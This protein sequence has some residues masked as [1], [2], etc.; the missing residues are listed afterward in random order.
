MNKDKKILYHYCSNQSFLNIV[1]TSKL[2]LFNITKSNDPKEGIYLVPFLEQALEE[3]RRIYNE[4]IA[5]SD[6][7][8][9]EKSI[10][11]TVE[12]YFEKNNP[13]RLYCAVCFS[14]AQDKLSQWVKYADN[15]RGFALG[16]SMEKLAALKQ[17]PY[18]RFGKVIYD[19]TII[20]K[21]VLAIFKPLYARENISDA[22]RRSEFEN[23]VFRAVTV[24]NRYAPFYKDDFFA[25]EE[26]WR[27]VF[28]PSGNINRVH[29][30]GSE[31]FDYDIDGNV[32][33][34]HYSG[35]HFTVKKDGLCSYVELDFSGIKQ[36]FLKEVVVPPNAN[37]NRFDGDLL[38]FLRA[39]GYD[40]IKRKDIE[41][42]KILGGESEFLKIV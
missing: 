30:R 34:F 36:S 40:W 31:Y 42:L 27:L 24:F 5:D 12:R 39:N 19:K 7:F 15:A 29:V 8:I 6:C 10:E 38:L 17:S 13:A 37:L 3:Q 23:A 28:A 20:S 35:M 18:F 21:E 1:S 14:E 16:F 33:G 11:Q 32:A 2:R 9:S 41:K 25:E 4:S 26:E 22:E